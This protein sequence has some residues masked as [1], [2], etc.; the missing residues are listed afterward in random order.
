MNNRT[1]EQY[2]QKMIEIDME[3]QS[4]ES[5]VKDAEALKEKE[6][7]KS[8]RTLE[9]DILKRARMESKREMDARIEEAK[10]VE[11]Q[12][13]RETEVALGELQEIYAREKAGLVK[14]IVADILT[15]Q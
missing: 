11:A 12:L 1:L 2:L 5:K 4:V 10:G 3:A 9:M 13:E 7:R 8:K 14:E 6:L 15:L